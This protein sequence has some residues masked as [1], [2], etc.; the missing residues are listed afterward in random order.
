MEV[1]AQLKFEL[2][3]RTQAMPCAAEA[4]MP[5][6]AACGSMCAQNQINFAHKAEVMAL[7]VCCQLAEPSWGVIL[8]RLGSSFEHLKY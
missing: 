4:V 6:V 3:S 2:V 8:R 1:R 7:W 5:K